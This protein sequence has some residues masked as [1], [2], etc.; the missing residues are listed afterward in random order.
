MF[1]NHSMPVVPTICIPMVDV[2]DVAACHIKAMTNSKTDGE[3]IIAAS[4]PSIWMKEVAK[5]LSEEFEPQGYCV[6]KHKAP[7]MIIKAAS[8]FSDQAKKISERLNI[9]CKIDNSKAK[10][11]L[12]IEFRDPKKSVVE[13]AYSLIEHGILPK[14]S[15]Y[16]ERN[17][18]L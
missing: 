2:R 3:R 8:L 13:M 6:P 7:D 15:G 18:K 5:A 9:D 11:M 12:N 10:Q 17:T 14:K 4:Q 16:K 1:L